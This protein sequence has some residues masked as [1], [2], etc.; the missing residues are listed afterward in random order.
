MTDTARPKD[1]LKTGQMLDLMRLEVERALRHKYPISCLVVG[2]AGFEGEA[3][4]EQRRAVMLQVFKHIKEVTFARDVRG[5][6][7]W[8]MRY[9]LA[10]FPHV[11]PEALGELADALL[12]AC[13]GIETDGEPAC[14]SI[15][16]AHNLRPGDVSF[17]SM[18]DEAET[19]MQLAASAGGARWVMACEVESEVDRLRLDIQ[20]Q[21]EELE[22]TQRC[23]ANALQADWGQ[24]LLQG[25]REIFGQHESRH[26]EKIALLQQ[27]VLGLVRRRVE[28]WRKTD[29]VSRMA[30]SRAQ[31]DRLER[32]VRKLTDNLGTTEEEL[33]RVA[34]MK[35]IDL[36]VSS[37]YRDVQGLSADDP[38][39]GAKKEM[40]KV[41]F[42]A[43][44]ALR[45]ATQKKS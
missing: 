37:I 20:R 38:G 19:G 32:R 34:A 16:V 36:G 23:E 13:S 45:E 33:R 12:A 40:L 18:V 28:D 8:T 29:I 17:E 10:V 31:I 22:T 7:V 30:E 35:N 44:V 14:L 2:L 24:P 6:G 41:L 43:N 25:L 4:K 39:S 5:L 11:E 42:E 15:G 3:R 9:E 26:D 21:I 1:R 27:D